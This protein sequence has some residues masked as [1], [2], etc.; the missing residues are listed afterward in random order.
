[1]HLGVGQIDDTDSIAGRHARTGFKPI[2]IWTREQTMVVLSLT[3]STE[4]R[5]IARYLALAG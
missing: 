2:K 3:R 1:M 5:S 4:N